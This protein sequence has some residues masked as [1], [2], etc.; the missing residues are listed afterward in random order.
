MYILWIRIRLVKEDGVSPFDTF[1]RVNFSI[2]II[3]TFSTLLHSTQLFI[4]L[5]DIH[6]DDRQ[7]LTYKCQTSSDILILSRDP[8]QFL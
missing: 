8:L 2:E 6:A 1:K 4:E 5:A 7:G 3:K